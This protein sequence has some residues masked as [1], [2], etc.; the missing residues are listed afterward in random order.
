SWP[1]W[2]SRPMRNSPGWSSRP[3]KTWRC[4]MSGWM[5]S[6]PGCGPSRTRSAGT[7]A[8]TGIRD[9][10]TAP[11]ARCRCCRPGSLRAGCWIG[12]GGAGRGPVVAGFAGGGVGGGLGG[13][14]DDGLVGVLRASRRLAAWQD[15]VEVAAVA[16]LDARRARAAGRVCSAADA[17]VGAELAA[18][19]VLTG[20]SADALVGL[21][22]ELARLP[23]VRRGGLAGPG[24][25]GRGRGGGPGGG[26]RA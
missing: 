18:A 7:G 26:G 6:W 25:L 19:L 8:R 12:L 23:A 13:V 22:R 14:S 5:R 21:A 17:Q 4:W 11:A 20:R 3:T 9:R 16:E 10:V 15:G 1:G 24:G 2:W